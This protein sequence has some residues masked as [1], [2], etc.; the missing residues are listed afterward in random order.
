[1]LG[2]TIKCGY[3][4][5]R[6]PKIWWSSNSVPSG[7]A[8]GASLLVHQA[9]RT[10]P[11][12]SKA[13]SDRRANTDRSGR[14]LRTRKIDP[15]R[16]LLAVQ[17]SNRPCENHFGLTP[18]CRSLNPVPLACQRSDTGQAYAYLVC[19][20]GSPSAC[21]PRDGAAAGPFAV[22]TPSNF[23]LKPLM[24]QSCRRANTRPEGDQ[25]SRRLG[26]VAGDCRAG[27]RDPR[28]REDRRR[29]RQGF[30]RRKTSPPAKRRG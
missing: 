11:M 21:E 23:G 2:A 19:C 9:R 20:V 28:S 1:M 3:S 15:E 18:S 12:R 5:P 6:W 4:G 17:K 16:S 29:R 25:P 22:I 7:R 27:P 30:S 26:V 13:D 8:N 14:K 10:R 24:Q